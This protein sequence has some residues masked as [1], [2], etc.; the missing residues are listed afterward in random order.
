MQSQ[1]S[2]DLKTEMEILSLKQRQAIVMIVGAESRG[3]TFSRLLKTAY[4]CQWCG[5]EI[6]QSTD[7]AAAR[8]IKR[9]EHESECDAAGQPWQFAANHST[10]YG[11]WGKTFKNCLGR[12]RQE[13]VDVALG[14][15]ARIL[16]IGTPEAARELL[17]QIDGAVDDRDKRL[18]AVA[19]LD[20]ADISTANKGPDPMLEW[21]SAL[22]GD[23]KEDDEDSPDLMRELEEADYEPED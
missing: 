21:L 4:S 23:N 20:R 16:Q 1:W 14:E 6:G 18:A 17:R 13:V 11:K 8:K 3:V 19:L 9:A 15:A 7:C 12:A 22:R 2:D 5:R 10:F